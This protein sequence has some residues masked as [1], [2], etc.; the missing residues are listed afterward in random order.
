MKRLAPTTTTADAANPQWLIVA[1]WTA[2]TAAGVLLSLLPPAEPTVAAKQFL[3]STCGIALSFAVTARAAQKL[4][5]T[6]RFALF[7][8]CA[9]VVV[10]GT[11]LWFLDSWI[12]TL[13]SASLPP[14]SVFSLRRYNWVYFT[15]LFALQVLVLAL[16]ETTRFAALRQREL[17]EAQ[18]AALRFQLN[19]HFLFNTLNAISA[20]IEDRNYGAAAEM[21]TRLAE[22]LRATL[23]EDPSAMVPLARELDLVQA[24]LEIEEVRFADRL[25]FEQFVDQQTLKLLVPNLILQA[26]VE[27]SVK[28]AVAP[29]KGPATI[30]ITASISTDSLV[31][32]VEDKA[33]ATKG[34]ARS[35]GLGVGLRNVAARLE[36]H[37]GNFSRLE[38]TRS[39]TGFT[40]TVFIPLGAR[41]P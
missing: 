24:Y 13:P 37:F 21:N 7:H 34:P 39:E 9:T 16:V 2:V 23:T 26:L 1:L 33:E 35:T 17:V 6:G 10:A 29:A 28:H 38:T 25:V 4:P 32:R 22:F 36:A 5:A 14:P 8:L 40:A 31:L 11:T 27:N 15:L 20:L 30:T 12:Q 19:P 41:L 3:T 18:L